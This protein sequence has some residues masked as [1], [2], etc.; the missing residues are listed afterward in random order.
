M[1]L[2]AADFILG[3]DCGAASPAVSHREAARAASLSFRLS[4]PAR[5]HKWSKETIY[6][7]AEGI[8]G[9]IPSGPLVFDAS[10]NIYVTTA[11]SGLDG[12]STVSKLTPPPVDGDPW[13]AT[14]LATFG[15]G[16]DG[17]F[18]RGGIL[19]GAD[20]EIYGAVSGNADAGYVFAIDP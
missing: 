7:F 4:P 18:P 17:D 9:T 6:E 19:L 20:G 5:G 13:T 14:T 12:Y 3:A 10:G 15:T 1:P 11:S 2:S 8:S 16:F